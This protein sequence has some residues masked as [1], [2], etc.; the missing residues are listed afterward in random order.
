MV[1]ARKL[2]YAASASTMPPSTPDLLYHRLGPVMTKARD[3]G[4]L[5]WHVA[6]EGVDACD[7][8]GVIRARRRLAP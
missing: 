1:G 6:S 7:H 8:R 3:R 5:G 4:H 2:H